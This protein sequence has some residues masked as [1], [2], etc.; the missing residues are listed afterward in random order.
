MSMPSYL[1]H[2]EGHFLSVFFFKCS[3]PYPFEVNG[4]H[5]NQRSLRINRAWFKEIL[6]LSF[7]KEV[8]HRVVSFIAVVLHFRSQSRYCSF[9]W[10]FLLQNSAHGIKVPGDDLI[11]HGKTG[12]WPD[13]SARRQ[14]A[15]RVLEIPR[16]ISNQCLEKGNIYIE[17]KEREREEPTPIFSFSKCLFLTIHSR[18]FLPLQHNK[19]AQDSESFISHHQIDM[20]YFVPWKLTS[21]LSSTSL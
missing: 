14:V 15:L 8:G 2:I 19:C 1:C 21:Y 7:K 13:I 5:K 9:T 10:L 3:L 4:I 11:M 16:N 18:F 6:D 12:I 20:H 17:K